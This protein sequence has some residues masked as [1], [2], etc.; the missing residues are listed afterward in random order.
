MSTGTSNPEGRKTVR[1]GQIAVNKPTRL[2]SKRTGTS[3]TP[4]V[5]KENVRDATEGRAYL[6]EHLL[7]CPQGEPVTVA[8]LVTCLHQVSNIKGIDRQVANAIHAVT[9]LAEEMEEVMMNETIRDA[10]ITHINELTLD[11]KSLVTDAKEKFDSHVQ[12]QLSAE[13]CSTPTVT[14]SQ[15]YY[16]P[17]TF[18]EALVNPPPHANPTLA[19]RGG[20]RARQFMLEGRRDE[21]D[22]AKE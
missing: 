21:C 8:S 14:P 20:I 1:E 18:A 12:Q 5:A 19:A 22:P 10:V 3:V 16:V 11:M 7:L 4:L 17:Q 13:T 15:P 9:F 6:E 2:E